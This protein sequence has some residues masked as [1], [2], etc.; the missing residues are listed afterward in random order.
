MIVVVEAEIKNSENVCMLLILSVCIVQ[1][2]L[3][4]ECFTC[5]FTSEDII[6]TMLYKFL[7]L[8]LGHL[9]K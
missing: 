4:V 1:T 5:L 6:T 2:R 8:Y 3:T 7:Y 9:G